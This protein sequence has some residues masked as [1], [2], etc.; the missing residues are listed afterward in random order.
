MT[1]QTIGVVGCGLMGS[2]IVE[3]AAKSGFDVIVG[4]LNEELLEQGLARVKKS[5]DRAVDRGKL[6]KETA[7]TTLARITSTTHPADFAPA[8]VPCKKSSASCV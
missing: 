7:E 4:E 6:D 2:G 5:L 1:I 8:D 3:V